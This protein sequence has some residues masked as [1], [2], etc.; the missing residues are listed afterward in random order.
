MSSSHLKLVEEQPARVITPEIAELIATKGIALVR[1]LAR[2]LASANDVGVNESDL[3][4]AGQAALVE[5]APE[6]DKALNVR[7]TT[8]VYPYVQGAMQ[9]E[10][11]QRSRERRTHRAI[12]RAVQRERRSFSS[13]Q[14]DDFDVLHHER[15]EIFA[16]VDDTL[17]ELA[18]RLVGTAVATAD[19]L[20]ANG[21][22]EERA[23][24]EELGVDVATLKEA[25]PLMPPKLQRLWQ[26]HYREHLKLKDYAKAAGISI[27][28]AKLYHKQL[29]DQ[30][31]AIFER[32]QRR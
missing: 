15:S 5:V 31:R 22:E 9:D 27:A 23:E 30:L 11:R 26:L 10:I 28:T 14:S 8:Y 7:F 21:T 4:S 13:T 29:R 25:L 20:L 18:A 24:A 19:E 17:S 6:F 32:K 1:K 16:Q 2:E 12:R 3:L